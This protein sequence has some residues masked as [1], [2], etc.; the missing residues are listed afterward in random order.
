MTY[1]YFISK[2]ASLEDHLSIFKEIISDLELL[3]VK[4][5]KEDLGLILFVFD[6]CIIHDL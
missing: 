2:G 1:S 6:A 5:D 4:F 3:E